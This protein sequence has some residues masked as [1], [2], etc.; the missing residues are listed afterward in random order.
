MECLGCLRTPRHFVT[1]TAGTTV[2]FCDRHWEECEA[3]LA[4]VSEAYHAMIAAGVHPKMA[5]RFLENGLSDD[6]V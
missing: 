3:D 1:V 5:E 6:A 2:Q 4:V